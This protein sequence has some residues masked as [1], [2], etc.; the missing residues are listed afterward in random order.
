M[1]ELTIKLT[2]TDIQNIVLEYIKEIYNIEDAKIADL[3]FDFENATIIY[4][5]KN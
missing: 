5:K 1:A 2:I 3:Q 4:T